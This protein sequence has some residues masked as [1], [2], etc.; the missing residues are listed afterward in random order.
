MNQIFAFLALIYTSQAF[1][2]LCKTADTFIYSFVCLCLNNKKLLV[3]T[4][5]FVFIKAAAPSGGLQTIKSTLFQN[6]S[7]QFASFR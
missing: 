2:L 4:L 3:N 6:E 1:F 5:Q 7:E